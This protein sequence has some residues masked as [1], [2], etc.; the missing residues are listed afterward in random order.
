MKTKGTHLNKLTR[1]QKATLAKLA[2]E[3]IENRDQDLAHHVRLCEICKHPACLLIEEAFLQ[4]TS[5]E[6]IMRKYSIKSRTTIYHHAHAFSL[7]EMRDRTLRYALGHIIEQ[8]DRV[9]VTARD[10]IQATYTYAHVNEE[11]LWM[12][13]ASKSEITVS[14]N[15]AGISSLDQNGPSASFGVRA[16]SKPSS[17]RRGARS[18]PSVKDVPKSVPEPDPEIRAAYLQA[19]APDTVVPSRSVSEGQEAIAAFLK[20]IP[21]PNRNP[22]PPETTGLIAT[23]EAN[24]GNP[25]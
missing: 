25:K 12:Q 9:N 16:V 13:P 24:Q 18:S 11:G 20:N 23:N 2:G 3:I 1:A 4:W 19:A 7:F 21:R 5:P 14:K 6:V 10:V 22:V 17:R 8:A 15:E